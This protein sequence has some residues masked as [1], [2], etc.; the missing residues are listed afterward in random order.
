MRKLRIVK[1]ADVGR[2]VVISRARTGRRRGRGIEAHMYCPWLCSF[3]REWDEAVCKANALVMLPWL[4]WLM[5][6]GWSVYFRILCPDSISTPNSS[7]PKPERP[8][9]STLIS[10]FPPGKPWRGTTR[11][12]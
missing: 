11:T 5:L 7:S 3:A 1:L 2:V 4:G 10:S 9:E 6:G 8:S 12:G